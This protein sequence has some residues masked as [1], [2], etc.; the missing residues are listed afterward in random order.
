MQLP[1][2]RW[3]AAEELERFQAA[4]KPTSFT[5]NDGRWVLSKVVTER[6]DTFSFDGQNIVANGNQATKVATGDSNEL[7]APPKATRT[8]SASISLHPS[9]Q[10]LSAKE[11]RRLE[12]LTGATKG[13]Q[14]PAISLNVTNAWNDRGRT[15]SGAIVLLVHVAVDVQGGGKTDATL[16][17][18][19]LT[20]TMK[21]SNGGKKVY[22]GLTVG[23]PTYAKMNPLGKTATTTAYEV[24]PKEDLGRL[25][26]V[27]V[28]ARDTVHV[29]VTFVV[30]SEEVGDPNDNRAIALK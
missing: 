16:R 12:P 21:L 13:A 1:H 4:P 3:G 8:D 10:K 26:S 22:D 30:G 29:V 6:G 2:T 11:A 20:L 14:R 27:I 9:A 28:P 23:A 7:S 25:G 24:D 18:D 15:R 17:P 19:M 5:T